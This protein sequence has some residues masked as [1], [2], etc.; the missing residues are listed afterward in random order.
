MNGLYREL[1]DAYLAVHVPKENAFW[2]M[3][4]ALPGY[5]GDFEDR[6]I[7][8]RNLISDASY[9]PRIRAEL[10]R[11]D[12]ASDERIGLEGWL[13]FFEANAVESREAQ[14]LQEKIIR[15]EGEL[16]RARGALELEYVDP[17][18]GERVKSDVVS[19]SIMMRTAPAEALRRAAF[20]AIREIEPH[21][22]GRGFI[23]VVKERNRLGRLMGYE[24]YYDMKVQRNEGFSKRR[25]FEL[26]DELERDTRDAQRR[27]VERL[28]ETHGEGARRGWN[29]GYLNAGSLT[30][31]LDPYLRAHSTLRRWGRSFAALGI[32]Y[33]GA[34]LT[35]DLFT[36]KGKYQN[37]FMHGPVPG[38]INEGRYQPAR[39]NFTS[40][41]TPSQVGAGAAILR[42]L[43]HEGGH[44]AHFANIRMPAP[45]FAQ[46]FAP[47]SVAFAE[48]QSMFCDSLVE[49]PDWRARYAGIPPELI[50]KGIEVSQR[51]QAAA[52]RGLLAV[53]YGEKA[54]YELDE[55]ALTPENI[56][57]VLRDVERRLWLLEE[58]PRPVLSVPHLLSG[59][60]S[61]YYHGYVLAEM[62]VA[63]TRAFFLERDG[64]LMDNPTIGPELAAGYWQPGNSRTFLEFV[65]D[66]TGEPFSG[67]ALVRRVDRS[68]PEA[69]AEAQRALERE[70]ATPSARGPVELD[71]RIAVKHGDE[72]IASNAHG[73]SF[74][75]LC[76]RFEAW[77]EAREKAPA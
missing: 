36:R 38:W 69:L 73:E 70:R 25:L 4:M 56:L 5:A 66:L 28:V 52:V 62:A 32:R 19:L 49:D 30:A 16:E 74:E 67:K 15:M 17:G 6:E 14:A 31:E 76:D 57:A 11:T 35:L 33:N 63:Q 13:R 42:T 46:E 50:R 71:A 64:Y 53:V 60:S 41:A 40:D 43:F 26:L 58:G 12:L 1:N 24:D 39:I 9:L 51:T 59:D 21:V 77:V 20:D 29:W 23:E 75:A 45:C 61:A 37:G 2:A 22:L 47:T 7:R 34:E 27:A 3:K 44:A 65:H 54:V 10:E 8:Y 55:D 72:L 48:T 18:S 68:L